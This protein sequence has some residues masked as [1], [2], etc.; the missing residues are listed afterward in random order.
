MWLDGDT[1]YF[2]GKKALE[3]KD[4]L[5]PGLHNVENYM[6]AMA[7]V[8][9]YASLEDVRAVAKTFG[10]VEHRIEL[11]RELDGVKYYNDSI[12]SS[13]TRT[14]A[15]LHSFD[16]QVILIAGG[17]DKHISF[18]PLGPEIVSHVKRLILCGATAEKIRQAVLDAP[19]YAPGH[20]EMVEVSTLAEAVQDAR[21]AAKAGDVVLLSPACAAFDQFKNFMVRGKTFKSLVQQLNKEDAG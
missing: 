1:V 13:P 20:P 15:G 11:V 19:D 4:I 9:G 18:A 8:E 16:Q 12:A 6:A 14:M 5:L 10:G 3:R 2:R 7:A 17:Y 21:R